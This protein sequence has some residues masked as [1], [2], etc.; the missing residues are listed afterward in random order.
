MI[1]NNLVNKK[2]AFWEEYSKT[3]HH[4]SFSNSPLAFT[5]CILEQLE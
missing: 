1:M 3:K 2:P 4:A 5:S